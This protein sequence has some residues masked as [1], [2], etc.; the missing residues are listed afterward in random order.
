MRETDELL[1]IRGYYTFYNTRSNISM[2]NISIVFV[3]FR[4]SNFSYMKGGGFTISFV[5]HVFRTLWFLP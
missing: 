3:F 2:F 5:S 4:E 1:I